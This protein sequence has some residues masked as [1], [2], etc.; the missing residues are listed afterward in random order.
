M[1]REREREVFVSEFYIED[2]YFW[3]KVDFI[4]RVFFVKVYF[5]VY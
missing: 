2:S 5:F 1:E 4:E 3:V